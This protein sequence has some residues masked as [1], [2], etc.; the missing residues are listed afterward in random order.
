MYK[1]TVSGSFH[2]HLSLISDAIHQFQENGC[3]VLSPR[4]ARI[5]A[6]IGDFLFVA[7]DIYRSIRLVENRHLFS[8]GA[9]DFLWLVA[10]DGYIGQS[11]S[12]EIGYAIARNK[13]I[14]CERVPPDLTIAEYVNISST[15]LHAIYDYKRLQARK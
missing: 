1:V 8:I 2:R 14:F 4:E 11:A 10:P 6:E 13:P 7:S 15:P 12:L 3:E 5:V 9:S